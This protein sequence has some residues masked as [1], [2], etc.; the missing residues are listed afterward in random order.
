MSSSL[1]HSQIELSEHRSR[2]TLVVG[3]WQGDVAVVRA[4]TGAVP[5][6][7]RTGCELGTLA[8]DGRRFYVPLGLPLSLH[9]ERYQATTAAK[10]ERID[11]RSAEAE[12]QPSRLECR[13]L[14]DGALQWTASDWSLKGR[15]HVEVDSGMVLVAS[16]DPAR[17]P[18]VEQIC[19]LDP[20]TGAVR[21]SVLGSR[22]PIRPVRFLAAGGGR[23]FLVN[24]NSPLP[25][26]VVESQTGQELWSTAGSYTVLSVPHR[27]LV[28]KLLRRR[29]HEAE[30]T[31]LRSEDGTDVYRMPF[32]GW[33]LHLLTDEGIAYVSSAEDSQPWVAAVDVAGGGGELWRAQGI[34]TDILALDNG[35]VYYACL[36][37]DPHMPRHRDKIAEVGALDAETGAQL[38]SWHSPT[39]T[40]ALLLL[41]GWRTPA[42][43]ADATKKSWDTV[44]SLLAYPGP[45]ASRW[46]VLRSEFKV[47][48]WRRPYALHGATNALWLEA[49]NGVVFVG[50]R[51]GLF[52]LNG[53]DGH[54]RWHA[55]PDIDLSFV[56]PAL[57]PL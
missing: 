55:L 30:F 45:R 43:L 12:A 1:P 32:G 5:W 48:Q 37:D 57:P 41:W 11:H 18:D 13:N 15:L 36:H 46:R 35:R 8:Q 4:Q 14:V 27:M 51:L 3:S 49:R 24:G 54:L 2:P 6:R 22:A 44:E 38:W 25:V 31:V 33:R 9:E 40:A 20:Q 19:A 42:M 34:R 26:Q 56:E 28:G 7:Q 52:A 47:G 39:D 23:T 10:R 16:H 17:P 29:N 50:T 53:R 21:W